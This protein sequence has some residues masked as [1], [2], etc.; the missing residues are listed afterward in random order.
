MRRNEN[1]TE[2]QALLRGHRVWD[3]T[4]SGVLTGR[5]G[6]WRGPGSSRAAWGRVTLVAT[7]RWSV[8]APRPAPG[9]SRSGRG[10]GVGPQTASPGDFPRRWRHRGRHSGGTQ[11]PARRRR[12]SCG[13]GGVAAWT[14]LCPADAETPGSAPPAPCA[15]AARPKRPVSEGTARLWTEGPFC[16]RPRARQGAGH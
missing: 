1:N 11:T 4:V 13:P 12:G 7:P 5:L 14:A 9:S 2:R 3:F 15:D 8:G 6:G 10:A 16:A